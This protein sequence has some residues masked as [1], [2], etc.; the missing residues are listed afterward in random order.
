[1]GNTHELLRVQTTLSS[2]SLDMFVSIHASEIEKSALKDRRE[3][4]P[5]VN[6]HGHGKHRTLCSRHRIPNKAPRR[7]SSTKAQCRQGPF[8]QAISTNLIVG[9][10]NNTA[11][12]AGSF[13]T[14]FLRLP[15]LQPQCPREIDDKTF[16]SILEGLIRRSETPCSLATS[17]ML[18]L[19]N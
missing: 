14:K 17:L 18:C 7:L 13:Q 11:H 19:L 6:R 8:P 16:S 5:T 1:M 3:P 12:F 9:A 2:G 15:N 10:I 4:T